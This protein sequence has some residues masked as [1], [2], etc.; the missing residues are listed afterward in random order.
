MQPEILMPS[1]PISASRSGSAKRF[2][3]ASAIGIERAVASLQ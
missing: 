1:L 2:E 3:I